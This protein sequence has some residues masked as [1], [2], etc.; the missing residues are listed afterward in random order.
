MD[1]YKDDSHSLALRRNA[2][3][4]VPAHGTQARPF[5]SSH[6]DRHCLKLRV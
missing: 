3:F 2:V 5:M 6:G 1:S 4:D